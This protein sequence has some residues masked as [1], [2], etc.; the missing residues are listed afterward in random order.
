M[1]KLLYSAVVLDNESKQKL[2]NAFTLPY[3]WQPVA[4]H[5]TI[6]FKEPVPDHLRNDIG[7]TVQLLVNS[8][9]KRLTCL[10]PRRVRG[11]DLD[12][13]TRARITSLT[14]RSRLHGKRPKT[15][16]RDATAL[17]ECTG[18]R[19]NRSIQCATSRSF[20]KIRVCGDGINQ[21]I[22]VHVV[23]PRVV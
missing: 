22:F 11:R 9:L 5:M 17:C 4:H 14:R 12:G 19:T 21:V 6:G 13:L 15:Y 1:E 8:I 23:T 20:G 2:I 3:K 18:N 7:K 16:Q 10:E